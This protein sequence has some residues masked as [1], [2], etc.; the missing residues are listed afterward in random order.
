[1]G[2]M[3]IVSLISRRFGRKASNLGGFWRKAVNAFAS[4]QPTEKLRE[5]YQ[6][7]SALR[8]VPGRT[9][10]Q[11]VIGWFFDQYPQ[12]TVRS[13]KLCCRERANSSERQPASRP[14]RK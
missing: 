10:R 5:K 9:F 1:M 12:K 14:K 8:L 6:V 7:D 4:I 11:L 13:S 3:P 2:G